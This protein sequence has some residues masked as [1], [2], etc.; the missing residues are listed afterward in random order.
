MTEAVLKRYTRSSILKTTTQLSARSPMTL[1]YTARA[2]NGQLSFTPQHTAD[3]IRRPV[4]FAVSG[5]HRLPLLSSICPPTPRRRRVS[6]PDFDASSPLLRPVVRHA[7]TA[8]LLRCSLYFAAPPIPNT[9]RNQ[10]SSFFFA[11][12]YLSLF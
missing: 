9:Y 11:F 8:P 3:T 7:T 10:L 6:A 1:S 2:I 5:F 12:F 4:T